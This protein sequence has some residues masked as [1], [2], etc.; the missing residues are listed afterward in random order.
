MTTLI[1]SYCTFILELSVESESIVYQVTLYNIHRKTIFPNI[2]IQT[3][4]IIGGKSVDVHR[5]IFKWQ[6]QTV[7]IKV[8]LYVRILTPGNFLS[9]FFHSL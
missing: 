5:F 3:G 6:N 1:T 9:L 2:R 7:T 4:K 8:H